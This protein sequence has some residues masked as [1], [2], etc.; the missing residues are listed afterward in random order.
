MAPRRHV[1]CIQAADVALIIPQLQDP[2]NDVVRAAAL[3]F[4]VRTATDPPIIPAEFSILPILNPTM[5]DLE[6]GYQYFGSIGLTV[7]AI[8]LTFDSIGVTA[9]MTEL[10]VRVLESSNHMI[11]IDDT[12][13]TFT[14]KQFVAAHWM[15][16]LR[17]RQ[18]VYASSELRWC[19]G[20]LRKH[21][22]DKP[23]QLVGALGRMFADALL[24]HQTMDGYTSVLDFSYATIIDESVNWWAPKGTDQQRRVEAAFPDLSSTQLKRDRAENWEEKY[25]RNATPAELRS[26]IRTLTLQKNQLF[27]AHEIR[28]R[29]LKQSGAADARSDAEI[30]ELNKAYNS[31]TMDLVHQRFGLD[32]HPP[33]PPSSPP[34][35]ETVRQVLEDYW[36][37][38]HR[39]RLL[40]LPYPRH[41]LRLNTLRPSLQDRRLTT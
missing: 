32:Q 12:N 35:E 21:A 14:A 23:L 7:K 13:E 15:A 1:L 24:H 40:P 30:V 18:P 16:K 25:D 9:R 19:I 41:L 28:E 34:S 11:I 6:D 37:E 20:V 4:H 8:E 5:K 22:N 36:H 29:M 10:T 2:N 31:G 33:S 39:Q 26:I 38:M 17:D 27:E 3:L